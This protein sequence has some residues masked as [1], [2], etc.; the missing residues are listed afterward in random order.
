[1]AEIRRMKPQEAQRK[2][3]AGE[4]LF[5]CAYEDEETCSQMRMERALTLGEL[6][7]RLAGLP[8]EQELIF[9]CK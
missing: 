6:N 9:Y 3:Q 8:R 4:A 2:V 5:V 1:M 7:S